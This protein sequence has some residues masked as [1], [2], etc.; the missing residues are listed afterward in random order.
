MPAVGT[1]AACTW[2]NVRGFEA[3]IASLAT[4]YSAYPPPSSPRLAYTSSPRLNSAAPGPTSSTVPET[5][6]QALP[7][8]RG[9]K[10]LYVAGARFPV[11]RIDRGRVNL[12]EHFARTG[13]DAVIQL[14]PGL[15]DRRTDEFESLS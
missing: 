1:A 9:E 2:S 14:A 15:L 5:S 3:T 12:D 11:E 8:R 7:G 4:A 6:D 13:A 10:F